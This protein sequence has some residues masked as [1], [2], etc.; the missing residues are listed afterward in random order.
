MKFQWMVK[1]YKSIMSSDRHTNKLK[2]KKKLK[3]NSSTWK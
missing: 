2:N 3:E 1:G